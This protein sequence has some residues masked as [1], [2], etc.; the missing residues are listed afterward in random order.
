[1]IDGQYGEG[2]INMGL[3]SL[4][5]FGGAAANKA[6]TQP[7]KGIVSPDKLVIQE[8][9]RVLDKKAHTSIPKVEA[10][11]LDKETGKI[12]K[13]TNQGNR[14][15]YYLGD[16]SRPTLINDRIQAKVENNP[17]KSLPNGNMASAHAEVGTIQQAFEDGITIGRDMDMKVLK[18]PICGYC[19]GDIAAMA[20]KAKLKSLTVQEE[21]TGK[22][23]YWEPGMKSLKEKKSQ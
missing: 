11:L 16:K 2:A 8:N 1:M 7:T 9:S 19:R 17:N 14:P 13:D 15:D 4:A 21:S 22:T 12:F 18:E 3:G 5:I 6:V 23:F 10:E 20:D